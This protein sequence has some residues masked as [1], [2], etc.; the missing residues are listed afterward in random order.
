M[1]KTIAF[2]TLALLA[3]CQHTPSR[4]VPFPAGLAPQAIL[5][6]VRLGPSGS[7][8]E[9]NSLDDVVPL[10]AHLD[11]A[12]ALVIFDIDDTLLS[13]PVVLG[14]A[15]QREFFGSDSWYSWQRDLPVGDR[16]KKACRFAFLGINY[17]AATAE[18][19]VDAAAVVDA[20]KTHKLILTSRSPDYRGGTERELKF[21]KIPLP[22]SILNEPA[23]TLVLDDT[24]MTYSNGILM[25]RGADK[26]KALEKLLEKS[27]QEYKDIVLVD[28]G[29]GNILDMNAASAAKERTFHG[30]LYTGIK[31]DINA[32][33]TDRATWRRWTIPEV[34]ASE[35]ERAWQE[36]IRRTGNVYPLRVSRFSTDGDCNGK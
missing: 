7:Y 16:Y 32:G 26:G 34:D 20:I 28:D 9:T 17:E 35:A 18:P 15:G 23:V 5:Q 31:R 8:V 36:W 11:P 12:T 24:P 6:E 22:H 4:P 29:W 14:R 2:A 30:I 21:A 13:T 33:N 10:V 1:I 25:T 3:G 27:P 19:T